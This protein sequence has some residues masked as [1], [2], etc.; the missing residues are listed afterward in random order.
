MLRRRP[1]WKLRFWVGA[2]LALA[3]WVHV[4]DGNAGAAVRL[5]MLAGIIL[6][7]TQLSDAAAVIAEERRDQTFATVSGLML[8]VAMALWLLDFQ[9]FY[10]TA[11]QV[12]E[13]RRN[14]GFELVMTTALHPDEIFEGQITATARMFRPPLLAVLTFEFAAFGAGLFLH[15]WNLR[16]LV[17]YWALWAGLALWT[18][19]LLRGGKT[20]LATWVAANTGQVRQTLRL[21]GWSFWKSGPMALISF[22]IASFSNPGTLL[23]GWREFPSGELEDL[24]LLGVLM[25]LGLLTAWRYARTADDARRFAELFRS[26]VEEP[27]PAEDDPRFAWWRDIRRPLPPRW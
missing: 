13:S 5:M 3:S 19:T 2:G 16:A 7:F 6:I 1:P 24:A 4:A 14:G 21:M 17:V 10:V 27:I 20:L 11:R 23:Q 22:H 8:T 15:H 18:W 9:M 12:A 26:V 25:V